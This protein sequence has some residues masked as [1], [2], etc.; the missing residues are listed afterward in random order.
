MAGKLKL[1]KWDSAA[2]LK[3]EADIAR[4]WEA[5]L[6]EGRDDPSFI[7]TALGPNGNPEFGTVRK[8]IRALGLEPP[9][10]RRQ[11]VRGAAADDVAYASVRVTSGALQELLERRERHTNLQ[12][13]AAVAELTRLHQGVDGRPADLEPGCHVGRTDPVLDAPSEPRHRRAKRR[14]SVCDR[15]FRM[16]SGVG[17]QNPKRDA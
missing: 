3:T 15:C 10:S 16:R 13:D 12:P 6:D 14:R 5:C 11:G 2:H 7:T 4:Y 9:R 8:V 1:K 17:R